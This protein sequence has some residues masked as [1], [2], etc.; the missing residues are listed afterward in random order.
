M[1]KSNFTVLPVRTELE[2]LG[3]YVVSSLVMKFW[4]KNKRL[5]TKIQRNVKMKGRTIIVEMA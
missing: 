2:W 5:P 4:T 3:E 1:K